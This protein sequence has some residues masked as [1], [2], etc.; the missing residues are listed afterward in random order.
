ME[1]KFLNKKEK[2]NILN[3]IKEQFE[4]KE[5]ILEENMVQN[6]DGKIF[7]ITKDLSKVNLEKLRI[8]ELGL[9]IGKDDKELRLT[10]EGSQIFG[11]N[12]RKNIHEISKEEV[13]IWMSGE[14][15]PCDKIYNGFVIVKHKDN[16]LGTGKYKDNEILNYVPKERWIKQPL[17]KLDLTE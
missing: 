9:Y 2:E 13:K 16:F 7:L 17:K 8:N 5:I 10:I 11:K 3:K 4:I 6:K 15:I 1:Y 14:D 12:A